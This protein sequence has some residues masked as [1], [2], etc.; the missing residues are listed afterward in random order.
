MEIK[1][2]ILGAGTLLFPLLIALFKQEIASV[3]Q[4]WAVYNSRPFDKD[5]NPNTPDRCQLYN[6]A[7]GSWETILIEKYQFSLDRDRR[8]VF[9]CHAIGDQEV[10]QWARERIPFD[11]WAGMRKRSL[12]ETE[13]ERPFDVK[14]PA[15][16]ST[17]SA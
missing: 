10:K 11:V 4:S 15:G 14:L 5:R 17:D 3:Y 6:S 16:K 13:A 2:L 12:P 8:G 7:T 9:I 1:Q